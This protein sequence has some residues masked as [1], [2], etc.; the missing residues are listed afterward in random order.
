[1]A[2]VHLF[3]IEDQPWFPAVLRDAATAYLDVAARV[4]GQIQR[5]G[6]K[7][8]EALE[9][10]GQR[11]LVDLCSGSGGPV[12]TMVEALA[13]QGVEVRAELTDLYPNKPALARA[14]ERDP[15]RIRWSEQPVDALAVPAD[16]TGM[17]TIFNALHHLRPAQARA[18]LGD[19]ARAGR[20]IAAFELVSRSPPV[21]LGMLFA[22]LMTMLLMPF[23]RGV[24]L[25]WLVF[26]YVI[27]L[28]PLVV[29]FD[30]I[31]SCLRVYAPD[32]LRA[33]VADID[34]PGYAWDIGTVP[35]GPPGIHGTYI[36]GIPGGAAAS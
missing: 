33:L 4:T 19:A 23:T 2:R 17:R 30:G 9:R 31:V 13:Q 20:P 6:P 35:M 12:V 1:M 7:L 28:V 25:S 15:Q 10:S 18:L 11:E 16:R 36:I 34:V 32:E 22:P 8:R 24:R 21:L 29:M 3:E 14:A 27:P 5:F 26:T